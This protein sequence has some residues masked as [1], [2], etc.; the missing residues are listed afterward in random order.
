MKA[1]KTEL[2]PSNVQETA[3]RQHCGAGRWAYN[4]GLEK[5]K[6]A[7]DAGEKWPSAVDLHKQ[8]NLIKGTDSLPWAY[9]VSK[10]AFQESLRNLE[11]AIKNM[12]DSRKGVR[13]GAKMGFPKPKTKKKG[14]GSC[15][16][17]GTIKVVD[18]RVQ[19]PRIGVVRLK[20]HGYIPAGKYAQATISEQA[21]HWFVSV[22][23]ESE[24]VQSELT[25][26]VVG[27]DV[28][29]KTLATCSDGD[30]FANPKALAA[31][32]KQLRRWQRRLSRRVKGGKNRTKARMQVAKL[33]KQV[34]DTRKDAH[35][36]AARAIVD[37]HP[38]IIVIENLNTKGMFKNRKLAKAL[39][40]AAFGQFGRILT[41]M[42]EDAGVKIVKA[43]RFFA[44]SKT[45][46][47]CGW[48]KEN[49][50]LSDRIFV[51]D[52][53]GHTMDRD[54]N[55]AINLKNTVSL[56]GIHAY[57][58]RVSP[59]AGNSGVQAVIGEIGTLSQMSTNGIFV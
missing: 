10:C 15:R 48:K 47:C 17:T 8:I 4:W 14:L 5:I 36:K 39:S 32:T 28:G 34:A 29:I 51:C 45:C 6:Q 54:L 25:D 22:V 27:V 21:G 59:G 40:D 26:E 57:G 12:R 11:T 37:K 49:L 3:L 30:V 20:E 9:E 42:A 33:H 18:G 52:D 44:S 31:K 2:D 56:T 35:N 38:S 43:G 16:F 50:A 24:V 41:Y 46:A 53:C 58:D 55:A 19:L 13:K 1:F 23:A 7:A